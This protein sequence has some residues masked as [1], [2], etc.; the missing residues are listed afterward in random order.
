MKKA[1]SLM[2][3]VF[4]LDRIR[5]YTRI[6]TKTDIGSNTEYVEGY[7]HGQEDMVEEIYDAIKNHT[8]E[9]NGTN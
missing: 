7:L 1:T 2:E 6:N 3:V 9:L 5:E 4:I 8:R